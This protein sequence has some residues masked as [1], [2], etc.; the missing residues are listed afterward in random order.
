LWRRRTI[1]FYGQPSNQDIVELRSSLLYT[2]KFSRYLQHLDIT[3]LKPTRSAFTQ[4]FQENLRGLFSH[5]AKSNSPLLSLRVECVGLDLLTIN[6]VV[7][8][9]FRKS[10]TSFLKKVG[11]RLD[12]VYLKGARMTLKEGCELLDALSCP[13]N[14]CSLSELNIRDLFIFHIRVYSSSTFHQC[15]AKFHNLV[16][17]TFNYNCVCDEVLDTLRENSGHSL[18][19]LNIKCHMYDPHEQVVRGSSWRNLA[20]KAPKLRVNFWFEGVM[21]PNH[22]AKILLEEIPVR[23]ISLKSYRFRDRDWPLSPTLVNLIP[24]YGHLLQSFTLQMNNEQEI[25]DEELLQLILSCPR[26]L[27]LDLWAFLSVTFVE[28]LLQLRAEGKSSLATI[29]VR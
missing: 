13:K 3:L 29:R 23:S 21:N 6:S 24:A 15:M 7:R 9:E 10:L 4:D 17:L 25:L 27:L 20:L 2:R 1:T 22:L 28:K 8:V 14:E 18:N 12:C 11:Q 26:L 16:V 19:T 5:L